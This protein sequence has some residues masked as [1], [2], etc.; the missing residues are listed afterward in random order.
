MTSPGK[1]LSRPAP[2]LAA[3]K[4]ATKKSGNNSVMSIIIILAIW[5]V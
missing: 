2:E 5:W 1:P 3:I 4:C